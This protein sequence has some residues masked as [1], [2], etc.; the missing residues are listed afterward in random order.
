M[1]DQ[2]G[3]PTFNDGMAIAQGLRSVT[4]DMQR[5]NISE[6]AQKVAENPEWKPGEGENYTPE[7]LYQG[8]IHGIAAHMDKLSLSEAQMKERVARYELERR[9]LEKRIVPILADDSP[10]GRTKLYKAFSEYSGSGITIAPADE[11]KIEVTYP[12][13]RK[14]VQQAPSSE[15]ITQMAQ[16][17]LDP[18]GFINQRLAWDRYAKEKNIE[19]LERAQDLRDPKSGNPIGVKFTQQI[20]PSTHK[21]RP[22]YIN[23]ATGME[24]NEAEIKD[25]HKK[26]FITTDDMKASLELQKKAMDARKA[27]Y[28][29]L[30]SMYG[31]EKAKA[32]AGGDGATITD[33]KNVERMVFDAGENPS[34]S[35]IQLIKKA[36]NKIGLDYVKIGEGSKGG[37]FGMGAEP[38]KYALIDQQTGQPVQ[39]EEAP[40]GASPNTPAAGL[41]SAAG[42]EAKPNPQ[43]EK[44]ASVAKRN[45]GESIEDYLKRTRK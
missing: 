37:W 34:E 32:E 3:R 25:L 1:P 20:D 16:S 17:I 23:V 36:A 31:A 13:G 45:P 12:D 43:P 15:Q 6:I 7:A 35:Q 4:Q 38:P 27:Q 18:R 19:W 10:E 14:S 33:I 44:T 21:P 9:E 22:V 42:G 39:D 28:D 40:A 24:L 30:K 41:A 11:G 2:W 5:R 26:G 29:L 8:R